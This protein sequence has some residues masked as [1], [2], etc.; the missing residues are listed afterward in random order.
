[1]SDDDRDSERTPTG[2]WAH[3]RAR[4][5][6]LTSMLTDFAFDCRMQAAKPALQ[7]LVR[8]GLTRNAAR[9]E[10]LAGK[11]ERFAKRSQTWAEKSEA[12][13]R[14]E[15]AALRDRWLA[16]IREAEEFLRGWQA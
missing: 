11:I 10:D 13:A 8:I 4:S 1:M 16:R 12:G 15:Q 9:A 7:P 14:G 2:E 5:A 6:Q 3:L